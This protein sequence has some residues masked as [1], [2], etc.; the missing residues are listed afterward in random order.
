MQLPDNGPSWEAI[1]GKPVN[2]SLQTIRTYSCGQDG[3]AAAAGIDIGSGSHG[4]VNDHTDV[5]SY[6]AFILDIGAGAQGTFSNLT[7]IAT[8][9]NQSR[10]ALDGTRSQTFYIGSGGSTWTNLVSIDA[11]DRALWLDYYAT[12]TLMSNVFLKTSAAEAAYIK[13][14]QA[15]ISGLTIDGPGYLKPT[16]TVDAIV[17]DTSAGPLTGLNLVNPVIK[18]TFNKARY[19]ITQVGTNGGA[20]FAL[21][22]DFSGAVTES[23]GLSATFGMINAS[24]LGG[25]W[26]AYTPTVTFSSGTATTMS[27]SGAYRHVGKTI[28]WRASV[29]MPNIGTATGAVSVTL[30]FAVSDV[31]AFNGTEIV[32]TGSSVP[33]SAIGGSTTA[34][35]KR[36]DGSSPIAN[37][38][39]LALS[40]TYQTP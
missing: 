25:T 36:Y 10:Y 1:P 14:P 13:S 24:A 21:G 11:G 40:G 5:G 17:L 30:P 22:Y 23:N 12:Q 38:N 35:F 37:N 4:S 33:G 19:G 8:A 18:N 34:T 27:V 28:E 3:Y 9:F 26:I 15:T 16:G 31:T 29:N 32:N 2:Y 7:G 20:G 6:G 39:F